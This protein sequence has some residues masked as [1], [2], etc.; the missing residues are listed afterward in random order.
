MLDSVVNV[1]KTVL[2]IGRKQQHLCLLHVRG[3]A[4]ALY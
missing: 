4:E 2:T 1:V 3:E